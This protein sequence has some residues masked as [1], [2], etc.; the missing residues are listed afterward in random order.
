MA[1]PFWPL[2]DLRVRTEHLELRVATDDD[3]PG[4]LDAIDAGIHDPAFMPFAVPWADLPEPERTRNAVQHWWR[5]RAGLTPEQWN[6]P[7]MVTRDGQAL[8]FQDVMAEH[9][10]VL[11]MVTTGSWL[12]QDVQGQGIGKEMR[13]A[14]LHLAFA[15][16]GADAACSSAFAGNDASARVS[17]A[18]GYEFDGWERKA[19]RGTPVDVRRYRLTRERWQQRPRIDV[20]VEALEPCLPLFGLG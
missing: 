13:A 1:H 18:L 4:L 2:F 15:G 12:R 16:L 20:E 14:V 19:P 10:A 11:R 5:A 6:L 8:G 7:L 9:F 17:E 3:F